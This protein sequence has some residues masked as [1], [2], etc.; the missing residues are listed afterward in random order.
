MYTLKHV[1]H[2]ANTFLFVKKVKKEIRTEIEVHQFLLAVSLIPIQT[3][4]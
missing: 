2:V 4:K 1:Y 3:E